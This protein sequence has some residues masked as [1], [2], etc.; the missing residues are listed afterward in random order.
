MMTELINVLHGRYAT[1]CSSAC[2]IEVG[3]EW[4]RAEFIILQITEVTIR[5]LEA[6]IMNCEKSCRQLNDA[7]QE[8][9]KQP[10]GIS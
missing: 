8:S 9:A 10:S 4:L 3:S 5:V 1:L 7:C 6:C 2:F